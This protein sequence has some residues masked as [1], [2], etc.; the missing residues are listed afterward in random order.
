MLTDLQYCS[1]LTEANIE[2]GHWLP[3]EKPQEVNSVIAR[4]ILQS[5][6]EHWPGYWSRGWT[7][8]SKVAHLATKI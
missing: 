4:W 3:Q 1:N 8:K 5:V 2:G 6:K 7:V